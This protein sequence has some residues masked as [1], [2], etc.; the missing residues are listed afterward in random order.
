[1]SLTVSVA[2][3]GGIVYILFETFF[4][5]SSPQRIYSKG[6]ILEVLLISCYLAL[7]E[8]RNDP[9]C[10]SILGDDIAGFGEQSKRSRRHIA[11]HAYKVGDEERV[12][13]TFHVKGSLRAGRVFVEVYKKPG[14][15]WSERFLFIEL[16]DRTNK[17]VLYD[18]RSDAIRDIAHV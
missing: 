2:L 9:N 4:S 12:R 18:H 17:I 1:M 11:S 7:K 16:A 10:Q 15:S 3:L 13:V 14:E 6:S 8:I 5:K